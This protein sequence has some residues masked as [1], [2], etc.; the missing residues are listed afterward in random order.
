MS[1]LNTFIIRVD[2]GILATRG[3]ALISE[4]NYKEFMV[5]GEQRSN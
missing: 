4:R 3:D 1:H 2:A 5:R